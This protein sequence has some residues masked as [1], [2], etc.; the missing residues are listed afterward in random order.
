MT[1]N[2]GL[3][4]AVETVV[5]NVSGSPAPTGIFGFAPA[6]LADFAP[7]RLDFGPQTASAS[8]PAQEVTITNRGVDPMTIS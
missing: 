2:V 4:P 1:Y 3:T 8:S 7:T 5:S 6:V